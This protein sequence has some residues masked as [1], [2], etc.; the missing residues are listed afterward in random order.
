[1][2]KGTWGST[3]THVLIGLLTIWWT[4]GIG[5]L[6]YALAAH[7]G[8]DQVMLKLEA[9]R[10]AEAMAPSAEAASALA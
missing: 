6:V 3:G 2:R 9:P 5:N 7:S 8:A 10:P 1:M 4:L